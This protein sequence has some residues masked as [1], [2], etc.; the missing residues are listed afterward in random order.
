MI[1]KRY[2]LERFKVA[3]DHHGI[4]GITDNEGTIIYV[5]DKFCEMSQYS[6]EELL[7]NNFRIVN[8]GHHS[9]E[10]FGAMWEMLKSGEIV[11]GEVANRR[12]DGTLYWVDATNVPFLND[13]GE[14]YQF[15]TIQRDITQ[16]KLIEQSL[17]KAKDQLINHNLLLEEKVKLR[18]KELAMSQQEILAFLGR[19][20]EYR[21]NE[22]GHHIMRMSH[23]AYIIGK[24]YGMEE[25]EAGML[26]QASKMHDIGKIGIP[27][28]ILLKPGKLNP[29]E[30]EIMKAHTTIGAGI[31]SGGNSKLVEL[32]ERIAL[33][34]HEKWDGTGYP[35]K[36][37]GENIPI[38]GRISALTDVFDALTSDRPYKKSW[39]LEKAIDHIINEKG[40]H[41]DPGL[42]EVFQRVLPELI[43]IKEK[44]VD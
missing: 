38:C 13:K 29:D 24:A 41:F 1:N 10:F 20:T 6:K 40:K 28:N 31:L 12:K 27:D 3:L 30:W 21:D 25:D 14:P 11:Q 42:V 43:A 32:A 16:R 22:T 8:S 39:P 35:N 4:V 15:V 23:Y 33:T 5:N 26:L 37:K 9:K 18:T 17:E 19:A 36:L 7:G 2:E 34:H 44:F